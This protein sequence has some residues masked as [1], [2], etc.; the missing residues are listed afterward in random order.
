MVFSASCGSGQNRFICSQF[1]IYIAPS[2][3]ATSMVSEARLCVSITASSNARSKSRVSRRGDSTSGAAF[4]LS[5]KPF[6]NFMQKGGLSP[7]KQLNGNKEELSQQSK[8]CCRE[9]NSSGRS[10]EAPV[11]PALYAG[12]LHAR[13]RQQPKSRRTNIRFEFAADLARCVPRKIPPETKRGPCQ[14]QNHNPSTLTSSRTEAADLSS[15]A[16]SSGVNLISI[17]C[18]IPRAPNFAGT[19]TNSPLIPYSPSR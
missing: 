2:K 12:P 17:I 11:G 18:S 15:A 1:S 13:S 16:C 10:R 14:T 5:V 8:R 3:S 9:R 4:P 7:S 6:R 19:P